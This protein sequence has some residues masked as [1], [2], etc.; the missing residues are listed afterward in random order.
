MSSTID[1]SIRSGPSETDFPGIE[2]FCSYHGI[3]VSDEARGKLASITPFH[4]AH[5][6]TCLEAVMTNQPFIRRTTPDGVEMIRIVPDG[7]ITVE[8]GY[9][10]WS[11]RIYTARMSRTRDGEMITSILY[12][13]GSRIHFENF[14]SMERGSPAVI[15]IDMPKADLEN[16]MRIWGT[17]GHYHSTQ[18]G[19]FS[20]SRIAINMGYV[21]GIW[22]DRGLMDHMTIDHKSQKAVFSSNNLKSPLVPLAF[23][24]GK[25]AQAVVAKRN[26]RSHQISLRIEAPIK[27][28]AI[29]QRVTLTETDPRGID[30]TLFQSFEITFPYAFFIPPSFSA[31]PLGNSSLPSEEEIYYLDTTANYLKTQNISR[32]QII[33]V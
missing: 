8:N 16:G 18:L 22:N 28:R 27:G 12:P 21:S 19:S 2:D 17:R 25:P 3:P 11:G 7:E 4:H 13:D 33:A 9:V 26:E 6:V 1:T 15:T 30:Q 29:T 20:I 10:D 24:G 23:S 14:P 5:L 32:I 31:F